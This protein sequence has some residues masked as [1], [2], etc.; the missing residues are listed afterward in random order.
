MPDDRI[1]QRLDDVLEKCS[2]IATDL[3]VHG[4]NISS[5]K[6]TV[7]DLKTVLEGNGDGLKTKVDRLEQ[8]EKRRTWQIR[9]LCGGVFAGVGNF[10]FELFRR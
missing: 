3:A 9:A 5:I 8:S 1:H 2:T 6:D 7:D 10:F 4:E